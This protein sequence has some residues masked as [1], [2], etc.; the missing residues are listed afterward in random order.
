MYC[1]RRRSLF[2]SL[3]RL[4]LPV[5][6]PLASVHVALSLRLHF[7]HHAMKYEP[8]TSLVFQL[9][10]DPTMS[11]Q[12]SAPDCVLSSL[13]VLATYAVVYYQ[14]KAKRLDFFMCLV[15][16]LAFIGFL[17]CILSLEQIGNRAER[18]SIKS[19]T[20]LYSSTDI[21][22]ILKKDQ[23]LSPR[24]MVVDSIQ[25]LDPINTW[26]EQKVKLNDVEH[27]LKDQGRQL[28]VQQ[29]RIGS[30]KKTIHLCIKS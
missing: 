20:Y 29:K 18:L 7:V 28:K 13:I 12:F 21:E 25:T 16:R 26:L 23:L 24:A 2:S 6:A 10:K 30:T 19:D 8:L 1:R 4:H 22:D 9:S 3:A 11:F 27:K 14:V 15:K 17:S 5:P